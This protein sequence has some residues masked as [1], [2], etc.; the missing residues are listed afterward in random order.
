MSAYKGDFLTDH[1]RPLPPPQLAGSDMAGIA[2]FLNE[3]ADA[4]DPDQLSPAD[5]ARVL[6]RNLRIGKKLASYLRYHAGNFE[7]AAAGTIKPSSAFS[8]IQLSRLT[9]HRFYTLM[10]GRPRN[11]S[12]MGIETIRENLK[13]VVAIAK[14]QP[15]SSLTRWPITKTLGVITSALFALPFVTSMGLAIWNRDGAKGIAE[16][17]WTRLDNR[18]ESMTSASP[19]SAPKTGE[20]YICKF[21]YQSNGPQTPELLRERLSYEAAALKL[22]RRKAEDS[23]DIAK[24]TLEF[25]H[26]AN[27]YIHSFYPGQTLEDSVVIERQSGKGCDAGSVQIDRFQP[28]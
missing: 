15:F 24:V 14:A 6:P 21:P 7:K 12:V 20:I 26:N 8:T 28:G 5:K 3:A 23:A 22:A 17:F 16:D 27:V 13:H 4:L 9:N 10:K 25:G 1:L 11:S 2:Q 18:L 19:F